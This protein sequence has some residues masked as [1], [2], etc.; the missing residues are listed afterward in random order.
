MIF[1]IK[2]GNYGRKEYGEDISVS[3]SVTRT[4]YPLPNACCLVW[5]GGMNVKYI[6]TG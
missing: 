5:K 1:L 6:P 4:S 3:A 2:L